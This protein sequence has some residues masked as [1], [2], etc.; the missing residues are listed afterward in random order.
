[1]T[2]V[3][4]ASGVELLMDFIEGVLPSEVSA[5]LEAH[6]AGCARCAAFVASYQAT[7]RILRDATTVTLPADIEA[8]LKAF[9]RARTNAFK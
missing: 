4:C 7:P 6:V 3:A 2:P 9:L 5:A 8:S 1:M